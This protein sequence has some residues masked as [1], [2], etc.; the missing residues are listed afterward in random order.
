MPSVTDVDYNEIS[1]FYHLPLARLAVSQPQV[2]TCDLETASPA[3]G[4]MCF[5]STGIYA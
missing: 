5:I 3:Q 4:K 1:L 2:K